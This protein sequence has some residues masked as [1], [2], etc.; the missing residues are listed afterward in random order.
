MKLK[1]RSI[2][3]HDGTVM[4]EYAISSTSIDSALYPH[5]FR[6]LNM[7]SATMCEE[8]HMTID[9]ALTEKIH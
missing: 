1:R 4:M 3:E 2:R 7:R 6:V 8:S 9:P 5:V